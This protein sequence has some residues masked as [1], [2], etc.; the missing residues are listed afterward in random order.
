MRKII[1]LIIICAFLITT[2]T[3]CYDADEIDDNI[4]VLAIGVDRGVSDKWRLTLQFS[5][6]KESSGGG[7]GGMEKTSGSGGDSSTGEQDG[8]AFV[9]I[10]APSFF[11]AINMLN[12]SIPRRL[13]FMHTQFLAF[14]E[15]LA[16]SG[17]IGEFIAPII[18]YRE[19]RRTLHVMVTK[20]S[21]RDFIKENKPFIGATLSKTMQ[22]LA[23]EAGDTSLLSHVTLNDFYNGLKSTYRQPVTTLVGVNDFKAF[24]EEGPKWGNE[25][26][27]EGAYYA[28]ELPRV[29][30][31]KVEHLGSAMFNGDKM[32]GELTGD[33]TRLLLM[34]EGE[35]K[36]GFYTVPDPQKPELIIPLDVRLAKHPKVKISFKGDKPIIH[37]KIQLEGDLLAVQSRIHYENPELKLLLEKSFEQQIKNRLDKLIEKCKS[38]NTDIFR[39]GQI[40]CRQFITIQEWEEYDW[41]KHFKDAEVTTEVKFTIR[42]T[43]TQLN[44]SPIISTEG[45]E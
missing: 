24:K 26:K 11:G 10:D 41:N 1:L 15:D 2:L 18:R 22:I 43:G 16:K 40:A 12:T 3:S 19:V 37:L 31:S 25:F 35:F 28:G 29:G 23:Q 44:S 34:A 39:F 4:H 27:I 33:E 17:L 38:L 20:G 8:Y 36:R 7:G 21:A 42:R 30:G 13:N 45:K 6:M 14:S 32:V 9:T 5:T